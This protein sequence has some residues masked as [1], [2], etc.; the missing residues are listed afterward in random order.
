[1][2]RLR[3]IIFLSTILVVGIIGYIVSLY[4][5]GYRLNQQTGEFSP[6]GLL[7]ANSDPN[8]ASVYING[9]LK[10]ATTAT[11][12]LLPATYDVEIKKDGFL[13]WY[14]RITIRK[15][16]VTTVNVTLFASAPSLSAIT[17]S[18]VVNPIISP[19]QTK[20]LYA[21]PANGSSISDKVGLWILETVNLPLGFSREPRLITDGDMSKASW[22]WSPDSREILL[23]TPVGTFL[24]PANETTP[25]AKRVNISSQ[26]Q[27][28]LAE[29]EELKT[30]QL[31]AQLA[32]LPD[33]LEDIFIRKATQIHFS[34]DEKK[35]LYTASGS[36]TLKEGL[37]PPLPGS[38][39]Q[40]QTREIVNGKKYIFDIKED[41]NF[42]IAES[43]QPAYWFNTSNHIV[44]PQTDSVSLIDYDGTNKQTVY[45]GSYV[46]PFVYPSTSPAKLMILTNFGAVTGHPNLYSLSLR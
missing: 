25:Q 35:I 43:T 17:F 1:M 16:E 13:P 11:I 10:T 6:N 8:G 39:T 7:V 26:K 33:E 4:A 44:L 38:S 46:F 27:K 18:G 41:R 2:T 42:E 3:V 24:L 40:K 21:V 23:T 12:P 22:E 36:A 28:I 9:E 31:Q 45:T 20:V 37:L 14:K 34:P 19:D 15:E 29:W 32:P 30:K 5:R